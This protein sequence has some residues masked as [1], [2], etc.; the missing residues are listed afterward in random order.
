MQA[1][2][3]VLSVVGALVLAALTFAA[4]YFVRKRFAERLIRTAESKAREILVIAKREAE[5]V[6]KQ[7]DKESKQYLSQVQSD[8]DAK[9]LQSRKDLENLEKA[10]KHREELLSEKSQSIDKKEKET[11]FKLQEAAQ[12]EKALAEREKNLDALYAQ[13][14]EILQRLSKLDTVEARQELLKRI[15]TELRQE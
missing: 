1:G 5:D 8:F 6:I 13:Q 9:M 4:G 3:A 7:A 12:K 14:R 11:L 2:M 15:E 10:L